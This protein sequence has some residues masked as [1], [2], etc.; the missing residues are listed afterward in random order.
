MRTLMIW[1]LLTASVSAAEV[2]TSLDMS[3]W[4]QS[5]KN[6]LPAM[7]YGLAFESG[8]DNVPRRHPNGQVCFT[9]PQ[10]DVQA[11]LT[12]TA[13]LDRLAAERSN[14]P[15]ERAAEAQRV[16][17]LKTAIRAR[18]KSGQPLTDAQIDLILG[19]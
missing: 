17:G 8:D 15:I 2:C 10:F 1:M 6:M 13:I 3:S 14:H 18:L 4:T 5:Q 16:Q 12:S 9:D 7:A 19:D 11:V